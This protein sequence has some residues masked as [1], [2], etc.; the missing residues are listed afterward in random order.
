MLPVM[1]PELS[2]VPRFLIEK[3]AV[4]VTPAPTSR[5]SPEPTL[6]PPT[7]QVGELQLPPRAVHPEPSAVVIVYVVAARA[8]GTATGRTA[9]ADRNRSETTTK[10]PAWRDLGGGGAESKRPNR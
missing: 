6:S 8:A 3:V 5:V 7:V 9:R 10:G 4:T 1:V 2:M